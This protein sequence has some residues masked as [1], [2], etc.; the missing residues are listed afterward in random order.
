MTSLRRQ[1]WWW[2]VKSGAGAAMML[3]AAC[4][5]SGAPQ[6]QKETQSPTEAQASEVTEKPFVSGGK[7]DMQLD[8]GSYTVRPADGNAIRVTLSSN[9]GAAKVDVTP[10]NTQANVSVKETPRNDF[11]ATIEVPQTADLVIRLAAGD[12]KVEAISGNKDIESNAGNVDIVTGDSKQ[13]ASVD[14]SVQAGDIK[15]DSFGESQSGPLSDFHL[16]GQR[17]V[18]AA[19]QVDRRQSHAAQQVGSWCIAYRASVFSASFSLASS[20][21]ADLSRAKI[22]PSRSST[23]RGSD[24]RIRCRPP[25]SATSWLFPSSRGQ[26]GPGCCPR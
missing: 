18:H 19:R 9:V 4:G 2:V 14:A 7:I 17:E 23:N 10:Q 16:G 13:Y 12:L 20:W 15:A 6:T 5:G 24:R 21:V 1:T 26:P 8:G 3:A 25:K 11:Q 22:F